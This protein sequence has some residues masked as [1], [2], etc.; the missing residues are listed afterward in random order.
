MPVS[1][2]PVHGPMTD[3]R[4]VAMRTR[5]LSAREV[6]HRRPLPVRNGLNPTATGSR[7]ERENEMG[8][9]RSSE[10]A[11]RLRYWRPQR[12]ESFSS[13]DA[14]TAGPDDPA[15]PFRHLH[16][17][18]VTPLF[19]QSRVRQHQVAAT[20]DDVG[21]LTDTQPW[22]GAS[23]VEWATGVQVGQ[24][25]GEASDLC[26]SGRGETRATAGG[27]RRSQQRCRWAG[28]DGPG[29]AQCWRPSRVVPSVPGGSD[30]RGVGAP[31][32]RTRGQ[33]WW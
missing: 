31:Q 23:G 4:S 17:R 8:R 19:L 15:E 1:S 27:R 22:C 13:G 30:V 24:I 12:A 14:T 10:C 3:A 33:G 25:L 32:G 26:L 29:P 6:W 9:K 5:S 11:Y 2:G 28:R 20:G 21:A 7:A 16:S 18:R